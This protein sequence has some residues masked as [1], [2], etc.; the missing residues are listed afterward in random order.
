MDA[1]ERLLELAAQ[2]QG[3]QTQRP[4][5]VSAAPSGRILVA[6]LTQGQNPKVLK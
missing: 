6:T 1:E 3:I 2:I 4:D 5:L